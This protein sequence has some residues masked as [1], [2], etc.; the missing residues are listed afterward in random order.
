MVV[1]LWTVANIV[2]WFI[3]GRILPS[4]ALDPGG[5]LMLGAELG[6]VLVIV[7]ILGGYIG[8]WQ[9]TGLPRLP[10]H[11]TI[12]PKFIWDWLQLLIIPIALAIAGIWYTNQQA[13]IQHN[14][15]E[16]SA[17][18]A[19]VSTLVSSFNL[20]CPIDTLQFSYGQT[21]VNYVAQE[22]FGTIGDPKHGTHAGSLDVSVKGP[23]LLFLVDSGLLNNSN[24]ALPPGETCLSTSPT[25]TDL[26]YDDLRSITLQE[27]SYLSNMK[28]NYVHLEGADLKGTFFSNANLQHSYFDHADLEGTHLI[29]AD[30]TSASFASTNLNSAHI[31]NHCDPTV[32]E[33]MDPMVLTGANFSNADL[34]DTTL[35]GMIFNAQSEDLKGAKIAGAYLTQ[36]KPAMARTLGL[37]GTPAPVLKGAP[38]CQWQ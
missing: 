2:S 36:W 21:A 4:I 35:Y 27:G 28:L 16:L 24:V 25:I 14:I 12:P 34:S 13:T 19:R 17:Y 38:F 3:T 1:T 37:K 20:I 11:D 5:W 30:V 32:P 22:A 31:G 15:D 23:F 18:E 10:A 9:A 7:Y 26:S 6:A 33:R 8:G 29:G